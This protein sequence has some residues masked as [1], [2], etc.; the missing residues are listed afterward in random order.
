MYALRGICLR[1]LRKNTEVSMIAEMCPGIDWL[2]M[3][4][5]RKKEWNWARVGHVGP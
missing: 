5:K 2:E 4:A 3:N 1:C